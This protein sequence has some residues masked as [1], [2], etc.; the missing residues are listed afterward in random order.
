MKHSL[1]RIT[2]SAIIMAIIAVGCNNAMSLQDRLTVNDD[3]INEIIS[4]MTLE[5]KVEM[6]HS[7]T[8][9]SSE[10]SACR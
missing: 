9:M 7:K 8:N 6:L 3:K 5:E 1:I 2:L 10:D 4:Q